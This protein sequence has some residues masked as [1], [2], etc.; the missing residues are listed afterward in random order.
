MP[1]MKRVKGKA[2]KIAFKV[3]GTPPNM[4]KNKTKNSKEDKR[5]NFELTTR[6]R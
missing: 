6:V 3:L 5:L 2:T 1:A 4:R